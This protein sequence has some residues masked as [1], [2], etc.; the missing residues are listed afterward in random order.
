[1][2]RMALPLT[3]ALGAV[4]LS[5]CSSIGSLST[6]SIFGGSK[7]AE[8]Q[9]ATA[10]QAPFTGDPTSRAL[11]VGSVSARAVKCG[12]NFDPAKL[13]AA[14][15]ANEIGLGASSEDAARID[16]IYDVAFNGVTKAAASDAGYCNE[17]RTKEI[18]NE[19]NRHLAGDFTP[20]AP[21]KVAQEGGLFSGWGSDSK[22]D[23]L[24]LK[25]PTDNR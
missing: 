10:P 4:A 23:G 6:G 3:L 11:Q 14:F 17:A 21:K 12:Y 16:R 24:N 20:A 7:S 5:A 15:L 1:M 2:T 19:L 8:V 9:P 13:K 22:D 18:K 25:L